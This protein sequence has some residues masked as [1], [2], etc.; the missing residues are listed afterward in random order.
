MSAANNQQ[1]AEAC[2][3]LEGEWPPAE[4]EVCICEF[5]HP[6]ISVS[7]GGSLSM[8]SKFID[9][10]MQPANWRRYGQSVKK[11]YS[12]KDVQLSLNDESE[13]W[14]EAAQC[15]EAFF[16]ELK[17]NKTIEYILLDLDV[18][19]AISPLDLRHFFQENSNLKCV[20]LRSDFPVTPV[21][22]T[23]ISTALRDVSLNRLCMAGCNFMNNGSLERIISACKTVNEL[24]LSCCENFE[25][26]ALA[27][28]IRDPTSTLQEL[29]INEEVQISQNL[30]IERA[31]SEIISSLN[32][33]SRL[34]LLRVDDSFVEEEEEECFAK[35]LCNNASLDSIYNSNHSLQKVEITNIIEE[36]S[37]VP[38]HCQQ[39]LELNKNPNKMKVIQ[40]KIM[41]H[42]FSGHYE[43]S[44]LA[45][46]PLAVVPQVLGIDLSPKSKEDVALQCSAMFNIV[47]S[48]PELCAVSSR[49]EVPSVG[50]KRQRV[51]M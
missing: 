40:H 36:E 9:R 49:G 47:K 3:L 39:Y 44:S 7:T 43:A 13:I 35:L 25:F 6:H 32:Q 11:C 31:Q 26:T 30:E 19:T 5:P 15:L 16:E 21:E 34:K 17:E 38:K 2:N 51:G 28:L 42:Y 4:I 24:S 1:F 45:N 33:N 48:I 50:N 12:I 23:H 22:S 29:H 37:R 20:E 41:K 46:M 27:E 8:P 14:P 18:S 10:E